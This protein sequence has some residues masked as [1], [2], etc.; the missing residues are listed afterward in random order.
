MNKN[1]FI[2]NTLHYFNVLCILR[3]V[4]FKIWLSSV[5]DVVHGI[6]KLNVNSSLICGIHFCTDAFEKVMYVS[7]PS[8]WLNCRTGCALLG[9]HHKKISKGWLIF[10]SC[11]LGVVVRDKGKLASE[12]QISI[13]F[14]FKLCV[15]VGFNS[16]TE[17]KIFKLN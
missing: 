3:R 15:N 11:Y 6:W 13:S 17:Q 2:I 5:I 12:I 8:Y 16:I 14:S 9:G 4:T 7:L 10:F 1:N